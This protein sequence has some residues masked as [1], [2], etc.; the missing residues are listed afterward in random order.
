MVVDWFYFAFFI[1]RIPDNKA[2]TNFLTYVWGVKM[3]FIGMPVSIVF[4]LCVCVCNNNAANL[5]LYGDILAKG[6]NFSKSFSRVS[7]EHH[8]RVNIIQVFSHCHIARFGRQ[9]PSFFIQFKFVHNILIVFVVVNCCC[10]LM[11]K[12]WQWSDS[13]YDSKQIKST[14]T[15]PPILLTA[16]TCA[17]TTIAFQELMDIE[18]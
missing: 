10:L 4:M 2:S 3:T 8:T 18:F 16:T 6:D 9:T 1:N 11:A 13:F 12:F 15:E 17:A 14:A 7:S 5:Y